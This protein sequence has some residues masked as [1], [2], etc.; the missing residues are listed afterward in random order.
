MLTPYNVTPEPLGR[1]EQIDLD[2]APQQQQ[3]D[4]DAAGPTQIPTEQ[5]GNERATKAAIAFG[6][7]SPGTQQLLNQVMTGNEE[8]MRQSLATAKDIATRQTKMD[9]VNGI[10]TDRARTGKPVSQEDV[11]FAQRMMADQTFHDPSTILESEYA[12]QYFNKQAE[13]K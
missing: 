4:L 8:A 5:V 10:A 12:R 13:L 1:P 11:D 3:I 7:A 9:I 6:D 2:P